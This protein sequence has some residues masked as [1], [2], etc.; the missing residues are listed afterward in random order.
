MQLCVQVLYSVYEPAEQERSV[1]SISAMPQE[2]DANRRAL[3]WSQLFP[4]PA[5]VIAA[6]VLAALVPMIFLGL[7]SGHDFEFHLNS[8]MEVAQQWKQGVVYPRWAAGAHYGFGEARFIFYPPGSWLLG[9]LL[10]LALPW[11]FVPVAYVWFA[12]VA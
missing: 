10:S 2:L 9:A 5:L 4:W 11:P 8:W 6:V 7:P 3:S 1:L 12:L